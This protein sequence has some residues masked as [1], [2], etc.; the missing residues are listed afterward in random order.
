MIRHPRLLAGIFVALL[1]WWPLH[2]MGQDGS[3]KVLDLGQLPKRIHQGITVVALPASPND[4]AD[5]PRTDSLEAI[6]KIVK[7]YDYLLAHSPHAADTIARIKASG[8]IWILYS[9]GF[10]RPN[11][12]HD[13]A[14]T[15]ATLNPALVV[16]KDGGKSFPVLLG[17]HLIQWPTA[18]LAWILGHE[19]VGH[20][21]Q[22]L[23]DRLAKTRLHD[24]ECEAF[25]HQERVSQELGLWKNGEVMVKVRRQME[26]KWCLPFRHYMIKNDKNSMK[27]WD[28]REMNIPELLKI[29]NKYFFLSHQTRDPRQQT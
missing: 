29:F 25:L 23:Q 17:Y 20:G 14:T 13:D 7:G 2:S 28:V 11:T 10:P 9:P 6:D 8:P 24:L 19:L 26:E 21:L 3:P 12:H 16:R 22:H 5:L 4:P 15:F 18:E 1:C 27:L